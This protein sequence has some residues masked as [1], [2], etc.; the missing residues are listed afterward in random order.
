MTRV[1]WVSNGRKLEC[2]FLNW[3]RNSDTLIIPNFDN[4]VF[5]SVRF[6]DKR[7]LVTLFWDDSTF[8]YNIN[9]VLF[10]NMITV[11]V[12]GGTKIPPTSSFTNF[13]HGNVN[14]F[15]N[16]NSQI[17]WKEKEWVN[18]EWLTSQFN[19]F[20][21]GVQTYQNELRKQLK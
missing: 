15:Y 1:H 19:Q 11:C 10:P 6:T 16:K 14:Y 12:V 18:E 8:R 3:L 9:R 7:K 21:V 2:S 20:F 5:P 4:V 13:E 17:Q